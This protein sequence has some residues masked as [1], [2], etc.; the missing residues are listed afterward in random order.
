MTFGFGTDDVIYVPADG[1]LA[2]WDVCTWHKVT[3]DIRSARLRFRKPALEALDR[4][5]REALDS[6]KRRK[7]YAD[8]LPRYRTAA[9]HFLAT[10]ALGAINEPVHFHAQDTGLEGLSWWIRVSDSP[11]E[12][13]FDEDYDDAPALEGP[14]QVLPLYGYFHLKTL[15]SLELALPQSGLESAFALEFAEGCGPAIELINEDEPLP[16]V[17][18]YCGS[19]GVSS[20]G[21]TVNLS[22]APDIVVEHKGACPLNRL[23]PG[24]YATLYFHYCLQ[25]P[26]RVLLRMTPKGFHAVEDLLQRSHFQRV[27]GSHNF[28]IYERAGDLVHLYIDLDGKESEGKDRIPPFLAV[29]A[30]AGDTTPAARAELLEWILN[31]IKG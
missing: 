23:A 22:P 27:T 29:A 8:E 31:A 15:A 1:R 13:F 16:L 5:L 26:A 10:V 21:N 2:I 12:S 4:G 30:A 17:D 24:V 7:E 18:E 28:T 6:M 25:D 14:T 19:H 20:R 9:K 11:A 3:F